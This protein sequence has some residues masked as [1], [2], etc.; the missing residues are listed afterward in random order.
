MSCYELV[1]CI[2]FCAD[3]CIESGQKYVITIALPGTVQYVLWSRSG[4]AVVSI[5]CTS[6]RGFAINMNVV[7]KIW[8][9]GQARVIRKKSEQLLEAKGDESRLVA[10][11][12]NQYRS[13][14]AP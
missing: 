11:N 7:W 6:T 5:R 3:L 4:A 1:A 9:T 10:P 2:G 12:R 13:V 8:R 14:S